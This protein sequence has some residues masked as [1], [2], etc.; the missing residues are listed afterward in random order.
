[1]K[2]KDLL[3]KHF[4]TQVYK[5]S[6][7]DRVCDKVISGKLKANT[8]YIQVFNM[9]EFWGINPDVVFITTA[10]EKCY[11]YKVDDFYE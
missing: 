3:L 10:N 7:L 2:A 5:G 11:L 6:V 4:S 1:M 8:V 9:D